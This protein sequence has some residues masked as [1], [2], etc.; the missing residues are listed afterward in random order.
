[1]VESEETGEQREVP[2]F[3]GRM[4]RTPVTNIPR[5]SQR[6]R[7]ATKKY[8]AFLLNFCLMSNVGCLI[9]NIEMVALRVEI[10]FVEF[11]W[12]LI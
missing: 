12:M 10:D 6:N 5:I 4:Q 9:S 3:L 2:C 7:A 8:Q 1:M 11:R